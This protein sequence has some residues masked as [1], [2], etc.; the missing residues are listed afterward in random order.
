MADAPSGYVD[1]NPFYYVNVA[2]GSPTATA[3][4]VLV[5]TGSTGL[6]ILRSALGASQYQ[7][8]ATTFKYAY[9]SGNVI[10]GTIAVATVYFPGA[11]DASGATLGTAQPITFGVIDT[12]NC[13]DG[14][15]TCAGYR[16]E[17]TWTV[18]QTGVMGVG[19][20][21]GLDVFNP[22][23][24]LAGNYASGFIFSAN[25][26]LG[27]SSPV[28]VVGLTAEN[29]AGFSF[30]SFQSNGQT[31]GNTGMQAWN[32]KVP[33]CWANNGSSSCFATIFDSGAVDATFMTD[34]AGGP[35]AS[36]T[37][38]PVGAMTISI[39]NVLS[40]SQT[41]GNYA[42][43][44]A[45]GDPPGYNA[46][47]APF[48]YYAVAYDYVNG[49]IGFSPVGVIAA[50]YEGG[51]T[52]FTSDA[53]LGLP[54]TGVIVFGA[55][56]LGPNFVSSRA[57]NLAQ[58][59]YLDVG[60][61]SLLIDGSVTLNGSL[62]SGN[63]G[64]S[65]PD[66]GV[67]F[68][69]VGSSNT[70]TLNGVSLFSSTLPVSV[71]DLKLVVNGIL[72]GAVSLGSGATLGGSGLIT[73]SLTVGSGATVA[74]GNSIGT[75]TVSG[76]VAFQ[77]GSTYSV[78]VGSPGSSDQLAVF[79]AV[80]LD[81]PMLTLTPYAGTSPALGYYPIIAATNGV[82]GTFSAISAPAFGA[83]GTQYPFI[84]PTLVYTPSAVV[85][86]MV[87]S[88]VSYTT[89]AQ[90]TNQYAVAT[91]ADRLAWSNPVNVALS[92]LNT[93][94]ATAA[95]ESLSG[96]AYASVQTGLQ[97]QS[98]YLRDAAT[99]R[100]RQAFAKNGEPAAAAASAKTAELVPGLALTAW[101]QAYGG[102]GQTEGDANAASLSRSIGGFLMGID[103]PLGEAWRVGLLGGYS[104]S[105]FEVDGVNSSA[106][107]DNYDLGLYGGAR[108]GDFG[109]RFGAGY[110][111]HDL[112][113]NRSL[114]FG[115]MSEALSSNYQAG[116]AQV[117]GEAGYG[118]HFGATTA[119]PFA[120]LAY[121]NLKTDGFTETGGAAALSG[122][123]ETFGATYSV[124]GLRLGHAIPVA[125]GGDLMLTGSLG[126]QHAYGGLTPTQ[127]AFFAGSSSFSSSGVPIGRDTALIDV[128][129]GYNP[130]PNI[131]VGLHYD[132][133][134]ASSAQDSA[135]KG[136]LKIKF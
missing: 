97:Q 65:E 120:D 13:K 82:S 66:V 109:L 33:A 41:L 26:A 7:D 95:L 99:A 72:P 128:G 118:F 45:H 24:Q 35:Y 116:T 77:P 110:T 28:L 89:A 43:E 93:D 86:D 135:I 62:S 51:Q 36:P 101:A 42:Y 80:S 119:E 8:T 103:S 31:G 90:T 32:T 12:L 25:Q 6:Y 98:V 69:G 48:L 27:D 29:T 74:P 133:A 20:S 76:N 84:A 56:Q 130:T 88:T 5:D 129:F 85:L 44:E 81:G 17:P 34:A 132:G 21:G 58:S 49:R 75:F 115:G 113:M 18:N 64:S 70:L 79:G 71:S 92:G 83:L 104:Q 111:W 23:T 105:T 106:D 10:T 2:I 46:S 78:E 47:N 124:L 94:T 131:D 73:G 121:V 54:G 126:W 63:F 16:S 134:F 107:S 1:Y 117:F 108:F 52:S 22:L 50:G 122:D 68:T 11:V 30:A 114:A 15:G 125:T 87:R 37:T 40:F 39:Q 14:P 59:S 127:T 102:W 67:T 4:S 112:S 60:I 100:L 55:M 61:P 91:V 3:N 136:T 123:S 96:Q 38:Y 19:F 53:D 57:F 9:S